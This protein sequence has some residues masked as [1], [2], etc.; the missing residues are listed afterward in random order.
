MSKEIVKREEQ[1]EYNPL[2]GGNRDL[3]EIFA[4]SEPLFDGPIFRLGPNR[5][6]EELGTDEDEESD[7]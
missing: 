6:I 7:E 4:D 2:F 5:P 1:D 3:D